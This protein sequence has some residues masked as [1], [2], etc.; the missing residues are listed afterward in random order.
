MDGHDSW[1]LSEMCREGDELRFVYGDSWQ[2]DRQRLDGAQHAK[3][4]AA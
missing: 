1:Y 3:N 2:E 4:G